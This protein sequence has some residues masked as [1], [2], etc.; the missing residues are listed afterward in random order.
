[1]K[2]LVVSAEVA[3]L[4]K[5]GGLADVVASLAK[6]WK[7][8]GY[9]PIIVMPKYGL[10]Y[11][12]KYN[13][14]PTD[15]TLIVPMGYWTEFARIWE[16]FLPCTDV[17][18][19]LIEHNV[20][21]DRNEI[22]GEQNEYPDN[23]RRFIF[24]SRASFELCKAI[25]FK[26]DIVHSHDYHAAFAMAFLKTHYRNDDL[27]KGT[28]GVFTIHNLAY[29]GKFDHRTSLEYSGFGAEN[30]YIG[31][32]FEQFGV[33][34]SMK[35]G[36]MFADKITT[37]SPTYAREIRWDYYSEGLQVEL[38]TRGADL[39]GILN[40]ADYDYWAPD[41]DHHIH[42]NY[43]V[44]T[45]QDKQLNKIELLKQFSVPEYADYNIPLVGM[46]TRLTEQKGLDLVMAE[47]E[48][49]LDEGYI[50]LVLLGAGEPRFEEYFNYL[51]WRYPHKALITIGYNNTLSHKIFASSDYFLIPSRYEPC[52][53]T[54][55]YAMSYG[56]VPIVRLTGGLADTVSEYT[57]ITQEGE[58]F[59]FWMY[60]QNEFS[61]ALTKALSIYNRK[62]HWDSIRRNCMTIKYTA[63]D[64]AEKY[65]E[66]FK[67]ALGK[68]S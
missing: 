19:Y 21:Y 12:D 1:M 55:M 40:G 59:R 57:D 56:T 44:N 10:V 11:T 41:I 29:Q 20:Y 65:I 14:K 6:E 45:L 50:R 13:F 25:N 46:V 39:L 53:L 22:Y 7:K 27:F 33:V 38:N 66:A 62:P 4:A 34:N 54:Q 35:I 63:K 18:I 52:G 24:F 68:I 31:S 43:N 42:Y 30:F 16:G 64:S 67:W 3:P 47:I 9:E 58:G 32:W 15:L 60:N 48:K 51:K 8:A 23:D 61:S 26:P 36:I 49:F 28:A 37:V 17:P 2:I 5:A